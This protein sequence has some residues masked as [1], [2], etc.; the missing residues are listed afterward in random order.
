MRSFRSY[1]GLGVVAVLFLVFVV[2]ARSGMDV[3]QDIRAGSRGARL[4]TLELENALL[5]DEAVRLRVGASAPRMVRDLPYVVVDVYAQYPF[6]DTRTLVID[7]GSDDGA[8]EGMPVLGS[9][10]VLVGK[11]V[12]VRR[13]QSEVITVYDPRW[14]TSVQVGY[15]EVRAVLRGGFRPRLELVPKGAVIAINDVV[16]NTLTDLPYGTLLGTVRSVE[17][18]DDDL[19][20]EAYVRPAFRLDEVREVLVITEFP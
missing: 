8:E 1:L 16:I 4:R 20:P 15:E 13:H 6:H 18:G 12:S 17:A 7:F 10:D 3:L 9:G 14:A 11:I 5:R 2:F 19:L